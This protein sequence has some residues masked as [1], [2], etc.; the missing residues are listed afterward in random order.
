MNRL[1]ATLWVLVLTGLSAASVGHAQEES[2][3]SRWEFTVGS[4]FSNI[5]TEVRADA[6]QRE[7]GTSFDLEDALE[8]GDQETLLRL[9]ASYR[10]KRRHQVTLNFT[11]LSRSADTTLNA[12]LR[13]RDI[14]FP[15]DAPVRSE[16]DMGLLELR[17]AYWPILKEKTAVGVRGGLGR[18]EYDIRLAA[19]L[20]LIGAQATEVN[21]D[22]LV[23]LVGGTVRQLITP[24]LRFEGTLMALTF[25]VG[26]TSGS[27]VEAQAA[28][29]YDIWEK[30]G[31]ALSIDYLAADV[32]Q[33]QGRFLGNY[34]YGLTGIQLFI[35]IR[36]D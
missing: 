26:D 35:P 23:P 29:M 25:D 9:S 7:L 8:L 21:L 12:E 30:V 36:F 22:E 5:D 24:K 16:F 32:D 18:W 28:F 14:A 11:E 6:S 15:V 1:H 4:F 31:I 34:K 3:V 27:I 33:D 19:D 2:L 17:Y 20:P 10:I 13:F